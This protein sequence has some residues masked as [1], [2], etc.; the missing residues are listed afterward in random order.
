M[1]AAQLVALRNKTPN[2]VVVT[3]NPADPK[4]YLTFEAYGDPSGGD[5]QYLPEET[6]VSS[7][8]IVKAIIH[9]TLEMTD[10][11]SDEAQA[12]FQQQMRVVKTQRERAAQAIQDSLSRG[13]DREMLG[14]PCVGPGT[15]PGGSCGMTVPMKVETSRTVPPLCPTHAP[16]LPKFVPTD[17]FD[18]DRNEVTTRWAM[19]GMT[20]RKREGD[21]V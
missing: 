14:M 15:V 3:P 16:L 2:I 13:D 18:R 1:P 7:P 6:A 21:P 12:S 9:E 20:E 10:E 5:F 8:P 19:M 17:H 11:L 4:T